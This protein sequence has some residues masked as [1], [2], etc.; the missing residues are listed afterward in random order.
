MKRAHF[1]LCLFRSAWSCHSLLQSEPWNRSRWAKSVKAAAHGELSAFSRPRDALEVFSW[2]L[3]DF[4]TCRVGFGSFELRRRE[5]DG[6]P[7]E[8]ETWHFTCQDVSD[9]PRWVE[10]LSQTAQDVLEAE[11]EEAKAYRHCRKQSC[12]GSRSQQTTMEELSDG[13]ESELDCARILEEA[14]AASSNLSCSEFLLL[15]A[16]EPVTAMDPWADYLSRRQ[17]RTQR[18]GDSSHLFLD[19]IKAETTVP[20][21]KWGLRLYQSFPEGSQPRKISD[22]IPMNELLSAA[23]YDKVLTALMMKYRPFL[24][25]AGPAS[26]D[27]YFYSGDCHKGDSF[28]AFIAAKEV[29]RQDLENHLGEK[30]SDEVAGRVLLRQAHMSELQRELVSLKDNSALMT[31]DEVATMLRQ[32]DRPELLAQAAGAELGTAG[33]KHYP[34]MLSEEVDE[35]DGADY[36]D[37][38]EEEEEEISELYFEDREYDEDE[39]LYIQAYHS[40]YASAYADVRKDLRDRRRERGFIK[41]NKT[42]PTRP[43]SPYRGPKGSGKRGF[44]SRSRSFKGGSPSKKGGPRMTRGTPDELQSRTKCF[45]CHELGHYARDCPLKGGSGGKGQG[46]D[47]KVSFVVSRGSGGGGQVFMQ[48]GSEAWHKIETQRRG[49]ENVARRTIAIFAGVKVKGFEAIVDTAAEDA[50]IGQ[51]AFDLLRLELEKVGLRPQEVPREGPEI[52]CAG[53]GGQATLASIQDV[54]VAIAGIHALLRFHVLKAIKANID[55]ADESLSTPQ[56]HNTALVRQPSGH[57]TVS[58]LD[59]R[60]KAWELPKQFRQDSHNPFQ[61]VYA[62]TTASYPE[63]PSSALRQLSFANPQVHIWIYDVSEALHYVSSHRGWQRALL[64]PSQIPELRGWNLQPHRYT[65]AVGTDGHV[66]HIRDLWSSQRVLTD[67]HGQVFFYEMQPDSRNYNFGGKPASSPDSAGDGGDRERNQDA[68]SSSSH[69]DSQKTTSTTTA[70]RTSATTGAPATTMSKPLKQAPVAAG[71]FESRS[72]LV[73]KNEIEVERMAKLHVDNQDWATETMD[74]FL[75]SLAIR[76]KGHRRGIMQGLEA[77][78]TKGAFSGIFGL[79]AHGAFVGNSKNT[80]RYPQLVTYLNRWLIHHYPELKYT[81]LGIGYNTRAPL[82]RDVNNVGQSAT[83]SFGNFVGGKLWLE[84]SDQGLAGRSS[85]EESG[86]PFVGDV[87]DGSSADGGGR[88]LRGHRSGTPDGVNETIY[89]SGDTSQEVEHRTDTPRNRTTSTTIQSPQDVLLGTSRLPTPSRQTEMPSELDLPMVDVHSMRKSVAKDRPGCQIL[90]TTT[91]DHRDREQAEGATW[92]GVP[93]VLAGAE[94]PVGSGRQ[95]GD[96]GPSGKAT[97]PGTAGGPR[98]RGD[99]CH[100]LKSDV[101]A[102]GPIND[103][104]SEPFQD[105]DYYIGTTTNTTQKENGA[106]ELNRD[107]RDQHRQRHL[108]RLVRHSDDT[109][110]ET[111][112]TR[113]TKIL[114]SGSQL[115]NNPESKFQK[116]GKQLQSRGWI[117]KTILLL[118][119][120]VQLSYPEDFPKF[121]SSP[122]ATLAWKDDQELWAP[123]EQHDPHKGSPECYVFDNKFAKFNWL[124]DYA[125]EPIKDDVKVKFCAINKRLAA[126]FKSRA[127]SSEATTRMPRTPT[128]A[129][130]VDMS[131]GWDFGLQEHRQNA[132]DVLR[133]QRPAILVLRGDGPGES[134]SRPLAE[135]NRALSFVQ[136]LAQIQPQ[137]GRGFIIEK[138]SARAL[139]QLQSLGDDPQVFEV[140][141]DIDPRATSKPQTLVMTNMEPLVESLNKRLASTKQVPETMLSDQ[142]KHMFAEILLQGIRQHLRQPALVIQHCPDQWSVNAIS[143]ACRHFHP[144]KL[145]VTPAECHQWDVSRLRFTGHRT[146][147]KNYVRGASKV[148]QD[149]WPSSE[150]SQMTDPEFWTGLTTFELEPQTLLPEAYFNLATWLAAGVSHMMYTFRESEASFQTEWLSIFPSHNILGEDARADRAERR[151]RRV[152]FQDADAD[153]ALDE[154]DGVPFAQEIEMNHDSPTSL[155]PSAEPEAVRA[156]MEVIGSDE[157]AVRRDLRELQLPP[158]PEEAT[159]TSHSELPNIPP[160]DIRRELFRV[161]RNLG[162]PDR[163]TFLRALKNAGVKVEYLKWVRKGFECPICTQQKRPASQ[164]PAHVAARSMPFNEVVGLDLFFLDRRIFLNMVCWGTDFQLVELIGDKSSSTVATAFAQ[165]WLA[166]YGPPAMVTCDQGTEF[167]GQDFVN[168]MSDNAT[169]GHFTD[170]ASPWQNSRT[171]KAGG[172]FKSRLAKVCQETAIT[173]EQDLKIAIA[174]TAMMHNKYYD[175]GGFTPHQR[176]FGSSLRFPSTL[177]SDDQVDREYL[178][179]TQTNHMIK[180][181]KIREAAMK[182]WTEYQDF[183]AVTRAVKS[184]TRTIDQLP[185]KVGGRVYV[186]RRTPEF[187]GWSGPGGVIQITENGRSLWISLRGYLLKTSKEQIRQAT[188]EE[189][190]GV[191]LRQILDRGLLEDLENGRVRNYRDVQGEGPPEMMIFWMKLSLRII[192]PQNRGMT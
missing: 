96:T 7:A 163:A 99:R 170:T 37:Y 123:P 122:V 42:S 27:R 130:S 185:L 191:E 160:A 179:D 12:K 89:Q 81:T 26:V 189:S 90:A 180:T 107:V 75:A 131:Q 29:A 121:L 94:E 129:R 34:V 159:S 46:K 118:I 172:V 95:D 70:T 1:N 45:N 91:T 147:V 56:G 102:R 119:S 60:E 116:L 65:M 109:S 14:L 8:P 145:P 49:E 83:I 174:E 3:S 38:E 15:L 175:R 82:H 156:A 192:H 28:A 64:Q 178:N 79:Y 167:T 2:K 190:F 136:V 73:L 35:D 6:D 25:V 32:L 127:D 103:D 114:M 20:K 125:G 162:H 4:A 143:L 78:T 52:P 61:M 87:G 171:E 33:A 71:D 67:W 69:K 11:A 18:E 169:V 51:Q 47:R 104:R 93:Q 158:L 165:S 144:R 187:R 157:Q 22:Q 139:H 72:F 161:H 100:F 154:I 16:P 181:R 176:V 184:N 106:R 23:G 36:D 10:L 17:A 92:S 112:S 57:R 48:S 177:L 13:V 182:A 183:Q 124:L 9:A 173:T 58:I 115:V 59:F 66:Q 133:D 97:S 30:L 153:D 110:R 63:D 137:A 111:A 135:Q 152:R 132:L 168:L 140:R 77:Q 21:E 126:H 113:P 19:Q 55:L 5:G 138:P 41:H 120:S 155:Q 76:N 54:P 44:P 108:V 186:W 142:G 141:V 151:G 40:A 68:P 24:E 188:S 85:L 84:D 98:D 39:S 53:I 86:L 146:T 164:R 117:M 150:S 31:F 50:V 88:I 43:R 101:A 148:V 128:T 134:H 62:S 74:A 166:H 80:G 149:R 105:K